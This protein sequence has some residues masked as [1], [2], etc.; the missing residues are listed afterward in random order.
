VA[1]GISACGLLLVVYFTVLTLISQWDFARAQ[2]ATF[3]YF[4]VPLAAGFG[5]QIGLFSYLRS[6]TRHGDG[7]G[8][9]VAVS[10]GTSTGAM[11]SC[12]AHYLA[13]ILP[14]L[15]A[16]GVVA[17]VAQYQIGL[18]WVGIAF[19]AGGILYIGRKLLRASRHMAQMAQQA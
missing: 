3:W 16:T 1:W 9:V 11:I 15:G 14:I 6:V 18:F 8:K 13:N 19:N 10:G 7:T 4:L 17:L 12:C 5:T 2:F